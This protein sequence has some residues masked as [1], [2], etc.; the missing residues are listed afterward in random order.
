MDLQLI[1]K[2][3]DRRAGGIKRLAE[4]VGMSEAN[5]HRCIRL[6][7]IKAGLLE[8]IA[9][10]LDVRIGVF[11]GEEPASPDGRS[12]VLAEKVKYQEA[13]IAEKERLI[14]V[15]MKQE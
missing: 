15:L 9:N 13:I 5:L 12:A 10:V 14:Q 4:E 11:F 1:K 6:N 7:E 8:K 3:S 2:Y